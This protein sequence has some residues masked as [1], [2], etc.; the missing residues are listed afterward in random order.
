MEERT[1]F[2]HVADDPYFAAREHVPNGYEVVRFVSGCIAE[3][4]DESLDQRKLQ[5][6]GIRIIKLNL[7]EYLG[8][9]GDPSS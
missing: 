9:S 1:L 6:R 3:V 2:E 4:D 7:C 5:W 8:G